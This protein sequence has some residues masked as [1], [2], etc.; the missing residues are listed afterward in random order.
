M[1]KTTFLG[2]LYVVNKRKKGWCVQITDSGSISA[3]Q[4]CILDLTKLN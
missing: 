3:Y 2:W 1:E 4:P